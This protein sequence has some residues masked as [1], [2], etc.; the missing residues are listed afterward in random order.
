MTTTNILESLTGN[1]IFGIGEKKKLRKLASKITKVPETIK[2]PSEYLAG[3]I[4]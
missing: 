2:I 3:E 1:L 4:Q